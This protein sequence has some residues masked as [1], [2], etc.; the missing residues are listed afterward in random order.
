MTGIVLSFLLICA[1]LAVGAILA[2]LGANPVVVRKVVHMGVGNWWFLEMR[3]LTTFRLAVVCPI[4]FI[5]LNTLFV[6]KAGGESEEKRNYGLIYYP[7][8]LLVLVILQFK[9]GLA[10]LACLTG[11]MVM[12]YGDSFAGIFGRLY[13]SLHFK[14]PFKEKTVLGTAMMFFVSLLVAS[15]CL[16]NLTAGAL[17]AA[18][19]AALELVTPLGLDNLSVPI[20]SALL[21]GAL[22]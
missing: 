7:V 17:V 21:A 22:L 2:R 4:V 14:G 10:P 20:L 15:V 13:G 5:V 11:V 3:Y 12:A 18:V 1:V 16:E 19:A 6:L 8:S 9:A